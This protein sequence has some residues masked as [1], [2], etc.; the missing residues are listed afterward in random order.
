MAMD[1]A[2]MATTIIDNLRPLNPRIQPPYDARML[3]F[4]TAICQ[5]MIDH[6]KAN[7]D[8]LP[9]SHT[10]LALNNP[11]GQPSEGADPQGGTVNSATTALQVLAGTGSAV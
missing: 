10:G 6:I 9:A 4:W 5:G 3:Q 2:Q 1:A 11:I 8:I 7:M